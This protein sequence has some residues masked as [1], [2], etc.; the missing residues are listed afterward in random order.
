MKI[1][2][3]I[4]F[5]LTIIILLFSFC[6][7][8]YAEVV[9]NLLPEN[10]SYYT[11]DGI[12]I[13]DVFLNEYILFYPLSTNNNTDY[14]DGL[15][16]PVDLKPNTIYE[17]NIDYKQFQMIN[18][19]TIIYILYIDDELNWNE[20]ELIKING[21][22]NFNGTATYIYNHD[23]DYQGGAAFVIG[24]ER[25]GGTYVLSNTYFKVNN[26]DFGEKESQEG[27]IL[28]RIYNFIINL[29]STFQNFFTDLKN[30]I[31]GF[32]TDLKT[33]LSDWFDSL[34]TSISGFFTDLKTNL[35]SWFDN[36]KTSIGDFI[37]N[38]SDN[39]SEFFTKLKNWLLWFN[40]EGEVSYTNPFEQIDD[41]VD[42]DL[43]SSIVKL[44]NY[45]SDNTQSVSDSLASVG[46][47]FLVF[48]AFVVGIPLV[49]SLI[50]FAFF[51]HILKR[52]LGF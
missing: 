46:S 37:D 28:K 29:P 8:A 21:A 17:C 16:Y 36:L 43:E 4:S 10:L 13:E 3:I 34:K 20:V 14:N 51:I 25:V 5:I 18:I 42:D 35:S 2:K 45:I 1:N 23:S 15:V 24:F 6:P 32:F 19:D 50:I 27:N 39:L 47:V 7:P 9:D 52:L 38:L 41:D 31:S 40:A 11:F 48:D 49:L 30:G 26:I 12:F 22:D 44:A 33:N